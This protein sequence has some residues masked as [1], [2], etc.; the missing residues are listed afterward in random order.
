MMVDDLKRRV[1]DGI[2]EI[3]SGASKTPTI[4]FHLK[5][6]ASLAA[7]LSGELL[8]PNPKWH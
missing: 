3:W 2:R 8:T 6:T 4:Y 1:R 7:L 5:T